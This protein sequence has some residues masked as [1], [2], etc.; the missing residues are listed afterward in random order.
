MM[1]FSTKNRM[2]FFTR[3]LNSPLYSFVFY[4]RLQLLSLL[5]EIRY[6]V[7]TSF[8]YA[9]N[10]ILMM[11]NELFGMKKTKMYKNCIY[12]LKNTL[13]ITRK[14]HKSE[15]KE[16]LG[17]DENIK[18]ISAFFVFLGK[19]TDKPIGSIRNAYYYILPIEFN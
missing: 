16:S 13:F 7:E 3:R 8:E 17:F 11:H 15:M 9:F 12:E 1:I 14:I 10:L 19:L 5:D 6:I 4:F 2:R 18:R